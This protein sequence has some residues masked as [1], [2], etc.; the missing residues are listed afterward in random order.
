MPSSAVLLRRR[1]SSRVERGLL[2]QGRAR[3]PCDGGTSNLPSHLSALA[4]CFTFTPRRP[5]CDGC[6]LLPRRPTACKPS[7]SYVLKPAF[8]RV[9]DLREL[10]DPA[11]A[12]PVRSLMVREGG[13]SRASARRD[14]VDDG[15]MVTLHIR[16]MSGHMIPKPAGCV[17]VTAVPP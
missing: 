5:H 6:R 11:S 16:V 3:L 4:Q 17:G 7:R 8:M 15:P 12:A 1:D 2:F 9:P 13:G 10:Y 14:F